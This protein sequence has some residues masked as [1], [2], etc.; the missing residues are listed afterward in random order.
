MC[1]DE[2]TGQTKTWNGDVVATAKRDLRAGEK[3]DGEGGYTVYG[4]LIP[5]VDSL[6]IE[7]LPI[8][9]AHGL[10]LKRDIKK[11]QGLSWQ[12]VEFSDESQAVAIR[13]EME[14]I[15]RGEFGAGGVKRQ[16]NVV[17]GVK[18]VNDRH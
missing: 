3:L 1:R 16:S 7:G 14:T 18:G 6:A 4:K 9:L 12:D 13:R 17:N 10:V 2:P 15:Y 5:A 11:D 8:G